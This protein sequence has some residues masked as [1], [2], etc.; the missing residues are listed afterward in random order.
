[1]KI[2]FNFLVFILITTNWA[3]SNEVKIFNFTDKEL[4]ELEVRKVRS[5]Q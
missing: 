4:S 1:M 5:L 3:N 2:F